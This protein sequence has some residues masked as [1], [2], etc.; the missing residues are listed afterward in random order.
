MLAISVFYLFGPC[1]LEPALLLCLLCVMFVVAVAMTT[2]QLS[3]QLVPHVNN[4]TPE[5]LREVSGLL[6]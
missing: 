4:V 2:S 6:T 5:S 1:C 3:G